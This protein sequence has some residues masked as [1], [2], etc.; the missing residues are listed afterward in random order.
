MNTS[1]H[2]RLLHVSSGRYSNTLFLFKL[3]ELFGLSGQRFVG[4]RWKVWAKGTETSVSLKSD[5][6]DMMVK[7]QEL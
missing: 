7:L 1:I 5:W 4:R 3:V 6:S 2:L